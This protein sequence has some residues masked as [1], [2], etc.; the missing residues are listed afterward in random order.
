[1]AKISRPPA[2]VP[3]QQKISSEVEAPHHTMKPHV[4]SETNLSTSDPISEAETRQQLVNSMVVLIDGINL[5][6]SGL[7]SQVMDIQGKDRPVSMSTSWAYLETLQNLLSQRILEFESCMREATRLCQRGVD[8]VQSAIGKS[9]ESDLQDFRATVKNLDLVARGFFTMGSDMSSVTG[10]DNSDGANRCRSLTLPARKEGSEESCSEKPNQVEPHIAQS[11][12]TL[13]DNDEEIL[14]SQVKQEVMTKEVQELGETVEKEKLWTMEPNPYELHHAE[15]MRSPNS[16]STST[17]LPRPAYNET[18]RVRTGPSQPLSPSVKVPSVRFADSPTIPTNFSYGAS[19]VPPGKSYRNEP[20]I[21]YRHIPN[22]MPQESISIHRGRQLPRVS[23]EKPYYNQRWTHVD[24]ATIFNLPEQM[25]QKSMPTLEHGCGSRSRSRSPNPTVPRDASGQSQFASVSTNATFPQSWSNNDSVPFQS[26]G[27]IEKS[28]GYSTNVNSSKRFGLGENNTTHKRPNSFAFNHESS[29][30]EFQDSLTRG[31]NASVSEQELLD[32]MENPT[33]GHLGHLGPS[34]RRWRSYHPTVNEGLRTYHNQ[35]PG[36]LHV[37]RKQLALPAESAGLRHSFSMSAIRKPRP[38]NRKEPAIPYA[39]NAQ[40]DIGTS[41]DSRD[42]YDHT[43]PQSRPLI[44]EHSEISQQGTEAPVSPLVA[45]RFPTLEQFEGSRNANMPSFPALPSMEPL[46]PL[47]PN[48]SKAVSNDSGISQPSL[49]FA[50]ASESPLPKVYDNLWPHR[51]TGPETTESSGDFF[52]RMT[53][54]GESSKKSNTPLS[55]V[56][57]G[58]A[59]PGARLVGPFDPL[60][61]TTAIHRHQL[62]EGVH[63]SN[64]VATS[65]DRWTT[66]N[67]RPYSDYFSGNGR[68]GWDHFVGGNQRG[69]SDWA[70]A[71]E[72]ERL[73]RI[74]RERARPSRVQVAATTT[75]ARIAADREEAFAPAH[76]DPSTVGKVQSCVEQLKDLGFGRAEDGGVG[77]LVVYAQAANG[78]LEDAIDM[79]DEERKAYEGRVRI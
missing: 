10:R 70:S 1:M 9:S 19:T 49:N 3:E 74:S 5:V 71:R 61:E 23:L 29:N 28:R 47:R 55:P 34:L 52:K 58:P 59:A 35:F 57:L 63:R 48:S 45:T 25:K 26:G 37:P 73:A 8:F 12:S 66:R 17:N 51:T 77:R 13:A 60:A 68:I 42:I 40:Q 62:I 75:P 56:Q 32:H 67:R 7:R 41:A 11:T 4:S 36:P 50:R 21:T 14:Q 31:T 79:I 53:G 33:N 43:V 38:L 54:I 76:G 72:H 65:S 22:P 64:T 39:M 44:E 24:S 20:T 16:V 78:D 69:L 2:A 6:A 27:V 46:V 15:L 18:S 30:L